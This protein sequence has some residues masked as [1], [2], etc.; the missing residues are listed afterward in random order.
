MSKISALSN[1]YYFSMSLVGVI[2]SSKL[3][4]GL[5]YRLSVF[6]ISAGFWSVNGVTCR[7]PMLQLF[8]ND[9]VFLTKSGF[10]GNCI[11]SY[12]GV[13]GK[14]YSRFKVVD[15]TSQIWSYS[16]SGV[17]L[18]VDELSLSIVILSLTN[19]QI[20]VPKFAISRITT[21]LLN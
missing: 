21:R 5:N 3:L 8:V 15:H 18:E 20:G 4:Y 6:L 17:M 2:L 10:R 16:K 13:S 19:H 12:F 14:H 11:T 1:Y 7:S 9:V